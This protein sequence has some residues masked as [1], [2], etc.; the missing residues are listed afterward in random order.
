MFRSAFA[1]TLAAALAVPAVMAQERQKLRVM[2]LPLATGKIQATV[3]QPFFENL[4]KTLPFDVD[5][6]ALEATGVKEFEQI[7][8][9]RSGIY[10][11]V[12]LRLGQ[13]SRDEP[14]ILGLDLV[15]M[16][17]DYKTALANV[18]AFQPVLDKQM[19]EKHNLKLLGVWPFGPQIIFC[20][21]PI[22][23]GLTDLKGKKIRILDGVM[24]KFMEKVGATPVTMAFG[25]V[26]QGLRLGTI[27]CA[28][29]GP[30]SANSAGWM[31]S[32]THVYALGLQVAV[33][34]YAIS[35]TAW[36]KMSPD[37]RS[38]FSAE[39]DKLTASI[40]KTSE[41]LWSDGVRCSTGQQP[42]TA[43][44]PFQAKLVMPSAADLA[45]VKSAVSEISVPA[46]A[47]ACDKV[48]PSCSAS[49]KQSVGPL[50]GIR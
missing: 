11:V 26:A 30:S 8:V 27:D 42:C 49:W 21:A 29:T 47:E 13:V 28:V 3:E 12:T 19:Q 5:Y 2:G 7:R 25:E 35:M 23:N 36:N 43:H 45:L 40:W 10:D 34:G 6:K 37:L 44:K 32:A 22:E 24:A 48:N 1:L 16:N 15:G 17:T 18:K 50:L 31:D 38:K 9:M 39:M 46:W 14:T 4:G 33:Q 41:E 20:K